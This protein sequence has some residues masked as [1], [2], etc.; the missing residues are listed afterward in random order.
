MRNQNDIA[1]VSAASPSERGRGVV[2]VALASTQRGWGGGE[3]QAAL[4]AHGLIRLG[5]R[6]TVIARRR[7]EFAE[8]MR[9]E[10]IDVRTIAGSGRSL[11]G[12]LQMRTHLR[13]LQPDVIHANDAHALTSTGLANVT[14]SI[15]LLIAA[16][17]VSFPI[18]STFRYRRFAHGV[19]LRLKSPWQTSVSHPA[20]TNRTF[21][22]CTTVLMLR[23][24]NPG[25]ENEAVAA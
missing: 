16:R 21:A 7:G 22:S 17:R 9:A 20:S 19:I 5:H 13:Q 11:R 3:K 12:L 4:L 15:P 10:G 1:S 8:R 2:H 24:H 25:R 6:C 14:L 18:R 23:L